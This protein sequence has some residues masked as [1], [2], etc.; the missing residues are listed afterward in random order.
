MRL[1]Y[2]ATHHIRALTREH[3]L[4]QQMRRV[5][6]CLV[7]TGVELP[8]LSILAMDVTLNPD[9]LVV[10]QILAR[11]RVLVVPVLLP[12]RTRGVALGVSLELERT[13]PNA[14]FS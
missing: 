1:Q 9:Y 4:N 12:R 8:I 11:G 3:R 5:Q 6:Y 2:A 14:E 13:D 10:H 7:A